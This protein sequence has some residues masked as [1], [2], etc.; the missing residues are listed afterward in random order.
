MSNKTKNNLALFFQ[1]EKNSVLTFARVVLGTVMFAHGA[2]KL[3]GW[4]GGYGFE[5]TMGFFT[6]YLGIPA[7]F[8]VLAILTEFFGSLF[9][10]GG[11]LTRLNALAIGIVM[12]VAALTSHLSAGFFMN[13]NG[14]INGEGFEFHLITLALA[15]VLIVKGGGFAALD[16]LIAHKIK[17]AN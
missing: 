5:G 11:F 14:Q 10:I 6:G 2:Q 1:T 16:N 12:I 7:F 9:L 13:W 17:A 8:G 3:L 15:V 4:F